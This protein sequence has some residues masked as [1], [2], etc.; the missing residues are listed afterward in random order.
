[1]LG[2]PL[3]GNQQQD[4]IE[5]LECLLD[6]LTMNLPVRGLHITR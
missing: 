3:S 2:K 1:M 5:G 6:N 4:A